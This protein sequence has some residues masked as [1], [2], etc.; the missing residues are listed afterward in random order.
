MN[1]KRCNVY[2]VSLI[3]NYFVFVFSRNYLDSP[4]SEVVI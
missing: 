3:A 4:A 1:K 2:S